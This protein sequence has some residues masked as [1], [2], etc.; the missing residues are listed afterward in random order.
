MPLRKGDGTGIQ[1]VRLGDG[2]KINEIRKGDG[3]VLFK[4]GPISS[5]SDTKLAHR[6]YLSES[7]DPFVDQIGSND[8]T[9]N[10]TTQVTGDWVDAAAR[11]GDG[12]DD[13]ID[14]GTLGFID[15]LNTGAAFAATVQTSMTDQGYV[16][17]LREG[18]TEWV[19]PITVNSQAFNNVE[20][21]IGFSLRD[22]DGNRVEG[23]TGDVNINDGNEHRIVVNV[24]DAST[25]DIE[26]WVDGQEKSVTIGTG[27]G[28]SNFAQATAAWFSH[29][30]NDTTGS[31]TGYYDGIVDD[32]C[33]FSSSL[34]QSEIQGYSNPWE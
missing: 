4:S 12:I 22:Q 21:A 23:Y 25:N 16:F 33:L 1:S 15:E 17:G 2:T 31:T 13:Y 27:D 20:G 9:N 7:T 11:Q 10:G 32:H 30:L 18:P 8:G 28:P 34:T 29:A 14:Y 19:Y 5:E 24:P 26:V 6:W 3:T